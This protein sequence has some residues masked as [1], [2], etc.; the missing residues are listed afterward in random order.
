[1]GVHA[2]AHQI[3]LA[4]VEVRPHAAL[5]AH[6]LAEGDAGQL[7]FEV[8]DPVVIDAGEFAHIAARLVADERTLVG[9]AVHQ[10]VDA[11]IQGAHDDDRR[12][13]DKGRL[14]VAGVR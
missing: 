2:Q 6:A 1:M 10:G 7:A 4:G 13:A 8:I 9:A 12:I 11:A 3:V 14:V 5:A